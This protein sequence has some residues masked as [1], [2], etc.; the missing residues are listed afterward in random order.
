MMLFN[1]VHN[2]WGYIMKTCIGTRGPCDKDNIVACFYFIFFE[3]V[4]FSDKPCNSASDNGIAHLFAYGK[5]KLVIAFVI[6]H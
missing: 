1:K 2:T 6:R 4:G 3:P 5:T